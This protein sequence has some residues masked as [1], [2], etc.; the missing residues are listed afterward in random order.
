MAN[1]Y[2]V[3]QNGE[4]FGPFSITEL[5]KVNFQ[6]GNLIWV[7]GLA[8]WMPVSSMEDVY[9]RI[10]SAKTEFTELSTRLQKTKGNRTYNQEAILNDAKD[11][12]YSGFQIASPTKRFAACVIHWT[13]L[14]IALS[15]VGQNITGVYNF[16]FILAVD[17]LC[18]FV[19]SGNLGHKLL[20]MKVIHAYTEED[21]KNPA[22][23]FLRET[24][25][26]LLGWLALP[27]LWLLWNDRR[28]NLYDILCKTVV[29]EDVKQNK[30]D[31]VNGAKPNES[32]YK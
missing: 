19:W 3:V 8:D 22:M 1:R 25:K 29:I 13:L 32:N 26:L 28:Q 27:W 12:T 24:L 14:L 9:N 15:I 18:Y 31:Y 21:I 5:M 4:Q 6:Q 10:G 30:Q 2:Y 17:A 16:I 23:G 20:K 11:V 7:N